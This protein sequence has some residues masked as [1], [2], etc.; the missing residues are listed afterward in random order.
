MVYSGCMVKNKLD[1][2]TGVDKL[3]SLVNKKRRISLNLASKE[4]G[5]ASEVVEE[6]AHFL[7][8]KELLEIKYFLT[9]AYLIKKELPNS[10]IKKRE[11]LL[12]ISK[13]AVVR[14]AENFINSLTTKYD[15][16]SQMKSDYTNLRMEVEKEVSSSRK[17]FDEVEKFEAM[18]R[19][20]EMGILPEQV[21]L[22]EKLERIKKDVFVYSKKFDLLTQ[23]SEEELKG[24]HN[25]EQTS[26]RLLGKESKIYSNLNDLAIAIKSLKKEIMN[27]ARMTENEKNKLSHFEKRLLTIQGEIDG[28]KKI[29]L[30]LLKEIKRNELNVKNKYAFI[31][32]EFVKSKHSSKKE[33]EGIK[34]HM[35][36]TKSKVV[37]M[38]KSIQEVL[39]D[40]NKL[41]NEL[42]LVIAET[43]SLKSLSNN[44]SSIKINDL[45]KK[46][47]EIN[48][49]KR[50]FENHLSKLKLVKFNK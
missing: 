35:E 20:I 21:L 49:E 33:L 45:K 29:F 3:V 34:K 9:N 28:K 13:E 2:F 41:V 44:S 17:H 26:E 24:I 1:I 14:N 38:D 47:V 7:E 48:T 43:K 40:Y 36:K 27:D 19:K 6:W 4:L 10:Q 8:K 16:L 39:L 46:L 12:A 37:K 50:K 23:K 42:H 32:A 25:H 5:V 31:L 15:Y 18:N 22:N 11:K 30:D